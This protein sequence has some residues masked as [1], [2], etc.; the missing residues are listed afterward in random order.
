MRLC[1]DS[2]ITNADITW[3]NSR[4][5]APPDKLKIYQLSDKMRCTSGMTQGVIDFG[6]TENCINYVALCGT[7]I[8]SSATVTLGYSDTNP[9]IPEETITLPVF[10]NFNQVFF[11]PTALCRRYWVI[12]IN[13]PDPQDSVGT[14]IGFLH[15]GQ[16]RDFDLV[17]FPHTPAQNIFSTVSRSP[18][19]QEYGRKGTVLYSAEYPFHFKDDEADDI[20]DLF[21]EI[22]T[23]DHVVIIPYEGD[24]SS[25][26]YRPRYGIITTEVHEF[27][28]DGA[29]SLY[30]G[31][32]NFEERM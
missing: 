17:E 7:N 11:L 8:S 29:P 30:R 9:N 21:G 25:R 22:Q 31:I 3:S 4:S 16:Y 5:F 1:A 20:L 26:R 18:S 13:D 24:Y 10:S 23:T 32:I 15:I 6:G 19:G 12:D 27:P 28:M 2:Q 14:E